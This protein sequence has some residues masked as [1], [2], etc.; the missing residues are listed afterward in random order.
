MRFLELRG[1]GRER[2]RMHGEA[3]RDTVREHLERWKA[4]LV[5]DL[6]VDPDTCVDEFLAD[7]DL[8]TA[9]VRAV[10]ARVGSAAWANRRQALEFVIRRSTQ[11][12]ARAGAAGR[13]TSETLC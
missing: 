4:A 13:V 1:S 12:P 2:G 6:V 8:V 7:T 5:D 10:C 11:A 3:L 9:A